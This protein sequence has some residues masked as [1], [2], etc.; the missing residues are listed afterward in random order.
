M[1]EHSAYNIM[2]ELA[3]K[4]A[5][6]E[7]YRR[8]NYECWGCGADSNGADWGPAPRDCPNCVAGGQVDVLAL[9]WIYGAERPGEPESDLA[10]REMEPDYPREEE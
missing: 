8:F 3:S 4:Q 9:W 7:A 5:P 1:T 6:L 2:V 10:P